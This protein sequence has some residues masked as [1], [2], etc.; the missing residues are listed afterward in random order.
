MS[1]RCQIIVNDLGLSDFN[2]DLEDFERD[3]LDWN[4]NFKALAKRLFTAKNASPNHPLWM[5][6]YSLQ[7]L[8][9]EKTRPVFFTMTSAFE[10][11]HSSG[12]GLFAHALVLRVPSCTLLHGLVDDPSPDVTSTNLP[13]LFTVVPIFAMTL[14]TFA[15]LSYVP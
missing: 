3:R 10:H 12:E 13:P 6:V 7:L 2:G 8:F 4:H 5:D 15:S 14:T 11:S 9:Y 1:T